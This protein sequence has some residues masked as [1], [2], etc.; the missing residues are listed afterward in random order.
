MKNMRNYPMVWHT[1]NTSCASQFIHI[2]LCTVYQKCVLLEVC[3]SIW[4]LG[5]LSQYSVWLLIGRP[6][7]DL[8]QRQ[9]IPFS[10]SL[11]VHTSSKAHPASYTMGTG[12]PFLGVKRGR[13]ATLTTH[14]I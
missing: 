8:R 9:T 2:I 14:S 6:G 10:S 5:Y 1:Q 12:G 4:E 13:G 3:F 11:C 7:F